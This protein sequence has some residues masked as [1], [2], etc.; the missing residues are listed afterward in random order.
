MAVHRVLTLALLPLLLILQLDSSSVCG[1]SIITSN[2]KP[3]GAEKRTFLPK[4]I[5]VAVTSLALASSI[6]VNTAPLAEAVA[7][8]KEDVK[9]IVKEIVDTSAAQTKT[10]V[11]TSAAQTK[12]QVDELKNR[13]DALSNTFF[14]VPILTAGVSLFTTME[15]SKQLDNTLKLFD[16]KTEE[17]KKDLEANTERKAFQASVLGVLSTLFLYGLVTV[18]H[19]Y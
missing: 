15:N 2:Q 9:E 19:H 16:G 8:T 5:E 10:Q 11:D 18:V 17:I 12:I 1:W 7:L 14:W 3:A 4:K 13:I 6:L